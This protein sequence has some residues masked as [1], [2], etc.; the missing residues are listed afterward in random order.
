LAAQF[1][2]LPEK[3]ARKWEKKAEQDKMRYAEEMKHY[4][5]IDD[6]TGGRKKKSKKVRHR[7]AW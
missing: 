1:K 4:V 2:Q 3:E 5:P 7:F 6:P